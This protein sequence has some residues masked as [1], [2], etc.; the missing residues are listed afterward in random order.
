[1]AVALPNP[2]DYGDHFT[3]IQFIGLFDRKG[4]TV[5]KNSGVSVEVTVSNRNFVPYIIGGPLPRP[6]TYALEMV[7]FHWADS[8]Y[9]QLITPTCFHKMEVHALHFNSRYSTFQKA[10][11]KPDGVA[12]LA[13]FVDYIDYDD[14]ESFED[15]VDAANH[16][17]DIGSMHCVGGGKRDKGG[18]EG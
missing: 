12:I 5:Y 4:S 13:F 7:L 2:Y 6:Y 18:I 10:V 16:V 9:S 17:L 15:S 8:V 11:H 14:V 1:M 3:P